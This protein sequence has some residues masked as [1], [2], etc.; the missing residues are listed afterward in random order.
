[1]TYLYLALAGFV[2]W[3]VSTVGGGG[4]ALILVPVV[5]FLVGVTAV[6]PVVTLT[7]MIAEPTRIYLFRKSI[8]WTIVRWYLPGA[9]VGATA[10]A[11]LFAHAEVAWLQ[12]FVG[13]F[14][15]S[16]VWQYRFGRRER[17]FRV[18]LWHF[19]PTGLGVSFVSGLIGTMGPVLNP[20]YLNYGVVKERMIATKSLNSFVM[21]IAKIGTYTAFDALTGR[22]FLFGLAAG[23]GAMSANWL[24]K[25]LLGEM[26]ATRFRQVVI[27]VMVVSGLVMLWQQRGAMMAFL[28]L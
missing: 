19:L 4:G 5:S 3:T 1:V 25:R 15:T 12:I 27:V 11:W 9:I 23:L 20:M 8:E 21:H 14:L 6:A 18:R 7:T 16:T 24:G 17:S 26:S 2:A 13:L 10:G 28:G 22:L